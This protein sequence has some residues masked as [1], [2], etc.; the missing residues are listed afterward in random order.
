MT[1]VGKGWRA[2]CCGQPGLPWTSLVLSLPNGISCFAPPGGAMSSTVRAPST[3]RKISLLVILVWAEQAFAFTGVEPSALLPQLLKQTPKELGRSCG[4]SPSNLRLA[5]RG[6]QTRMVNTQG[7]NE[8]SNNWQ[9]LYSD[10]GDLTQLG[11]EAVKF[12]ELTQLTYDSFEGDTKSAW[13]KTYSWAVGH[14]K[15]TVPTSGR[16]IFLRDP[17]KMF[18][19]L[20]PF[21]GSYNTRDTNG[22][23]SEQSSFSGFDMRDVPDSGKFQN[24]ERL[25]AKPGTEVSTLTI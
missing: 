13:K 2:V 24:W 17:N 14:E 5:S 21:S 9:D 12:G 23:R 25:Y 7:N 1:W 16:E 19:E 8:V 15:D 22:K 6:L 4:G 3:M 11:L 18:S 10:D 20:A